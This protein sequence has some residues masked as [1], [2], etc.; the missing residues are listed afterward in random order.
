MVDHKLIVVSYMV[1]IPIPVLYILTEKGPNG[2]AVT[3]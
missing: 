3:S 2:Q 1:R